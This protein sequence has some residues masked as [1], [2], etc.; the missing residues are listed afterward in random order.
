MPVFKIEQVSR[1]EREEHR[2]QNR[3][4]QKVYRNKHKRVTNTISN[5]LV[6][7]QSQRKSQS[8]IKKKIED[9]SS[10]SS[11]N[12]DA[13]DELVKIFKAFGATPK[14]LKYLAKT[15]GIISVDIMAMATQVRHDEKVRK[16]NFITLQ[17]ILEGERA[18][19]EW[20]DPTTWEIIPELIR[21]ACGLAPLQKVENDPEWGEDKLDDLQI[22]HPIKPDES[23][24]KSEDGYPSPT[25]A[26][27]L[28]IGQLQ[29]E[30]P[31]ASFDTWLRDTQP[32][33]YED[34]VFTIATRNKYARDWLESRLVSTTE[35]LLMGIMNRTVDVKF[36]IQGE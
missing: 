29:V 8:Q 33:H 7:E 17:N 36:V 14:Q 18:A 26:W 2:E 34:G 3:Q 4:R 24:E 25:T 21:S 22:E 13:D 32:I 16:P 12:D 30:M 10:S 1:E 11:K 28:A 27:Q 31:K 35:R 9:S 23:V 6:T 15:P 20:Q 19:A 5:A